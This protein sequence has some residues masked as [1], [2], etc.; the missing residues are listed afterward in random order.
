MVA[1]ATSA[2]GGKVKNYFQFP[3]CLLAY[4]ER[5]HERLSAI[6]DY[7]VVNYAKKKPGSTKRDAIH[8]AAEVL[9]VTYQKTP[10]SHIV[11]RWKAASEFV[12][13]FE[14]RHGKD[15]RVRIASS[16]LWDCYNGELQYR[17]FCVLCALNSIIGK[18][19]A[20]KRVTQPSIRV[21]AAGYKSWSVAIAE[22]AEGIL[23]SRWQIERTLNRLEK[24]GLFA[25]AR[26]GARTVLF[27]TGVTYE[28]LCDQIVEAK[29]RVSTNRS[30]KDQA[31]RQR[32]KESERAH[33]NNGSNNDSE[34]ENVGK[35]GALSAHCHAN[36]PAN[37]PAHIN[38]SS[39][40]EAFNESLPNESVHNSACAR[41]L[42]FL[43][44]DGNVQD[45]RYKLKGSMK[46]F[47]QEEANRLFAGNNALEFERL[48]A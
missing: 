9:G 5:E 42:S 8:T 37:E 43:Q 40:I 4:L 1:S 12:E 35:T 41:D 31:L 16:L 26:T 44:K 3:L 15:A 7:N 30:S 29:S 14:L 39:L 20:P 24:R 46:I 48:S 2:K 36:E 28:Q 25:R 32:I 22:G 6:I 17:E 18:T 27:K 33:I 23:M 47:G 13:R 38:K 11:Q 10:R 21:R 34:A 19:T 45:V